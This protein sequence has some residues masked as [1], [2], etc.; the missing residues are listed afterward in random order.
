M[1]VISHT[2]TDPYFNLA[3]EQWLIDNS[4]DDVFMLW[5][6]DRSV[7]VGKNQNTWGEVDA[8]CSLSASPRAKECAA[9]TPR[10]PATRPRMNAARSRSRFAAAT[11]RG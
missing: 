2:S 5:R 8:A 6:N 4:P 7:I 1:R 11:P 3:A 9:R 10:P